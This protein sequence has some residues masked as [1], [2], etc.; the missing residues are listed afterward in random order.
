MVL[1]SFSPH[2]EFGHLCCS[3]RFSCYRCQAAPEQERLSGERRPPKSA[4]NALLRAVSGYQSSSLDFRSFHKYCFDIAKAH[5]QCLAFENA[6]LSTAERE[7][8]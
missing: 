7:N 4:L 1:P 5:A 8:D 6:Q 3:T 2:R